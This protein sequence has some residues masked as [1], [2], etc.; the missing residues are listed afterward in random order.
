MR[1]IIKAIFKTGSSSFISIILGI[2]STKVMAVVLGSSGV[3]LYSLI[4]QTLTA[5]VTVGTIGGSTALVQGLAS[6]HG[7]E[8]DKYLK[9]VFWIFVCGA[10]VIA[11]GFSLFSPFIARTVFAST[12]EKTISLVRW[13][14][15][16]VILTAVYY[17]FL[18]FLNGFGAIGRL[19][20]GQIIG[21]VV[22]LSLVYP[23]SMLVSDGYISAFTWII[24][25]ST[26]G[27]IIFY[28]TVAHKEKW[29]NPLITDF[30][31]EFDKDSIKHF[32]HIASTSLITGL[33]ASGTIL[34]I[35]SMLLRYGGFSSV[36]MFDVAWTLSITYMLLLLNS[37]GTYYLPSLC[38]ISDNSTRNALMQDVFRI[39]LLLVVPLIVTVMEFKTLVITIFYTYEFTPALKIIR[40][41]LIGDYFKASSWILA[42]PMIAYGDMKSFF[43][44]E[45]L[46]NM[47]FLILSYIGLFYFYDLQLIG[48]AF[49]IMY[50]IYFIITIYYANR[51]L[52]FYSN[53]DTIIHW[54]LGLLLIL[55]IT[56]ETWNDTHVNWISASFW[57]VFSFGFSWSMLNKKEKAI[58]ITTIKNSR[59][60]IINGKQC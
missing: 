49:F 54:I 2:L 44:I 23:I 59:G 47:I 24:S 35:R 21:S 12:D 11:L 58:V 8:K 9:T 15:L 26:M 20:I 13:M 32:F 51:K 36:G 52:N 28:F 43:W 60:R 7:V 17:Y 55:I 19:A 53:R 48:A 30:K 38:G 6:K 29:L 18:S 10:M 1:D 41:M 33:I 56:W 39:S 5:A 14:T 46:G 45:F 42:M 27:A 31:P 4:N 25:A 50:A 37:F 40:W 22:T 16:P 3:G 34:I 57:I